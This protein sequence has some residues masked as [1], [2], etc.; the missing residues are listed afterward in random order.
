MQMQTV[1]TCR[2]RTVNVFVNVFD[3]IRQTSK[4]NAK[5]PHQNGATKESIPSHAFF[6]PSP[7]FLFLFL[8]HLILI[9]FFFLFFCSAF[10]RFHSV[11]FC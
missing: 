6:L 11:L 5:E 3:N 8:L 1:G 2:A 4:H 9:L 7:L 10:Y